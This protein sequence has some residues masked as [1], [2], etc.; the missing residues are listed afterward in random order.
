[1]LNDLYSL[2][3]KSLQWSAMKTLHA[4]PKRS[5]HSAVLFQKE[6]YIFGGDE[7][8]TPMNDMWSFHC[9]NKTW[10]K[11]TANGDIPCARFAHSAVVCDEQMFVF[12]GYDGVDEL[13]DMYSYNFESK[14]WRMITCLTSPSKRSY[15]ASVLTNQGLYLIGGEGYETLD[16]VWFMEY[17]SDWVIATL[18]ANGVEKL[19]KES[20]FPD[21]TFCIKET[22]LQLHSVIMNQSPIFEQWIREARERG[23]SVVEVFDLSS[24]F[25]FV[26][27]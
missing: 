15:H 13:N 8:S 3:L 16:D 27:M 9:V 17:P 25:V 24:A 7:N 12:G 5:G 18:D 11:I 19:L 26:K 22:K 20:L 6:M 23:H 1:D 21:I 4:P 2:N 14:R 10:K